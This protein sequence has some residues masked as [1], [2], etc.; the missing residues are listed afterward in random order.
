MNCT[1]AKKLILENLGGEM[2]HDFHEHLMNCALCRKLYESQLSV[3]QMISLKAYEK[4]DEKAATSTVSRIMH[5]IREQ[6]KQREKSDE[7]WAWFFAEPRYGLAALIVLFF[8]LHMLSVKPDHYNDTL[9][10]NEPAAATPELT[11]ED[12]DLAGALS[13]TN[14]LYR[15]PEFNPSDNAEFPVYGPDLARPENVRFVNYFK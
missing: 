15:Y 13:P 10:F 9:A 1:K 5:E 14:S 11:L 3:R 6:E 8:A 7:K 2:P 4:P 12:L